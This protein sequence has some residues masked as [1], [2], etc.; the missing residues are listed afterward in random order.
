MS[1]EPLENSLTIIGATFLVIAFAG[2]VGGGFLVAAGTLSIV[3]LA[4]LVATAISLGFL[5]LGI[6][7]PPEGASTLGG[8]GLSLIPAGIAWLIAG[9]VAFVVDAP[10]AVVVAASGGA[11]TVLGF[12]LAAYDLGGSREER[13]IRTSEE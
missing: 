13:T 4:Y 7:N 6:A 11:V 9:A 5:G 12:L 1:T 8:A 10:Y 2:V 3:G